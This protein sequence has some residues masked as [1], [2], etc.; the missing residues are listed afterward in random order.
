MD[1]PLL[2][3]VSQVSS[4]VFEQI[5][6]AC[7]EV[8][9]QAAYIKINYDQIDAYAASLT[10]EE[11]IAAVLDPNSHYLDCEE[12]TV[13]FL[14]TLDS[15]NFGSGFF[16][17]LRKRPGMSGY[18][19]IASSLKDYYKTHGPLPAQKLAAITLET[20]FKIFNQDPADDT[21]RILMQH[22]TAALN[23]LG[24]YILDAFNGDFLRL[25]KAAQSSA[26]SFVCLLTKMRYFKDVAAYKGSEVPF[27]KRAQ[28]SVA[29]LHVAFKGQGWG[30]FDD[31]DQLTIFADNLVPHVLRVDNVLQYEEALISR[32]DSGELIAAGSDEEVEIRACAVHAVE[33]LKNE[34]QRQR[35]EITSAE[36]DYLLWN[37]GQQPFYKAIPR[38]RTR[39]VYY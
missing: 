37:R 27:Y 38:H 25:V 14:L 33:L 16:P 18:F 5:R 8:A 19:T 31:F 36:L 11:P 34:L 22:F 20:C 1:N 7:Q 23:D 10:V 9:E 32:I 12:D 21:I 17:C 35:H 39:T 26:D 15:I 2:G 6:K 4:N 28:I 24:R 29:D 3:E 13:A 30:Q